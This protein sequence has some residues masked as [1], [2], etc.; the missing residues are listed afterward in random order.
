MRYTRC[1]VFGAIAL[2]EE[3]YYI[4]PDKVNPFIA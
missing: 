2:V 3:P 1:A 4:S